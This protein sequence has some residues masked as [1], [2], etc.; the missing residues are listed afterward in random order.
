VSLPEYE[1][2][3]DEKSVLEPEIVSILVS[4]QLDILI[5]NGVIDLLIRSKNSDPDFFLE[6]KVCLE[7]NGKS[8]PITSDQWQFLKSISCGSSFDDRYKILIYD[9]STNLYALVS[10]PQVAA[11]LQEHK[12]NSTCYISVDCLRG[13]PW[14]SPESAELAI[15]SW[16]GKCG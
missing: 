6:L 15:L 16:C 7:G 2:R 9:H 13:L 14:S 11:G 5:L 8:P 10:G 12:P 3:P 4:H 1:T